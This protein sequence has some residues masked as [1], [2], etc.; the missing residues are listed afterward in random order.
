VERLAP[1]R[2]IDRSHFLWGR[3][4]EGLLRQNSGIPDGCGF[5]LTCA[6]WFDGAVRG[7]LTIDWTVRE[8]VRANLRVIIKRILRRYGYPPDEQARAT[9]LVLEQAQVLCVGWS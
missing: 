1:V 7:N 6:N 4:R 2:L 3:D 5:W 9:E 8:N